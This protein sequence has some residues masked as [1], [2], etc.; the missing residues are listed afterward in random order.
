[1]QTMHLVLPVGAFDWPDDAAA[2]AEFRAR[3]SAVQTIM[4][5]QN[6]SGVLIYGDI[7]DNGMLSY[8]SN[9]GARLSGALMLIP[10]DGEPRL[11]SFDGGRMVPAGALTT[12]IE[13]VRAAGKVADALNQ[14]LDELANRNRI[15]I[16]GFDIMSAAVHDAVAA[17][18]EIADA[19]DATPKLAALARKKSAAEIEAIK[20]ACG[21]LKQVESAVADTHEAG[22]SAADCALAAEKI[23]RNQGA[24]DARTL[25]SV[26]RGR[27]FIPFQGLSEQSSTPLILYVAVRVRGS[28][29]DGFLTFPKAGSPAE[30]SLDAMIDA[31]KPGGSVEDLRRNDQPPHPIIGDTPGCGIGCALAEAPFLDETGTLASGDVVSLKVGIGG[32][33]CAVAS[34]MVHITDQGHE[35]LWRAGQ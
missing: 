21:L 28:W 2:E 20:T 25:F 11:L 7:H 31:A 6:W 9:F 15:A 10:G 8:F 23:A 18:A 27:T 13:D 3:T 29:A 1:M 22:A 34:A 35:I 14:W 16:G 4:E 26:D 5:Q 17:V 32:D 33:P 19:E 30:H 12:W 24:Q